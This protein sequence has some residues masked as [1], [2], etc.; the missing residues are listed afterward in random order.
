MAETNT[1][2]L[3]VEIIDLQSMED[4]TKG[5]ELITSDDRSFQ[6]GDLVEGTILSASK[7][8]MI[9]DLDGIASGIIT[10]EDLF[11]SDNTVLTAQP[12][13]RTMAMI[14]GMES[15]DGQYRM[16]LKRAARQGTW[17]RFL[18]AFE[19]DEVVE[20]N[21]VDANKGGL[22]VEQNGIRGFI[23]V[24]QLSPENYP[25]VNGADSARILAKLQSLVGTRMKAKILNVDNAEQRLIF[26]EREAYTKDRMEVIGKLK[27]GETVKCRV[28]GVVNFGVFLNY[29]GIEGLVHISEIAWGHVS[30]PF[31]FYKAGDEVEA[32]IISIEGEKISFSIKRLSDDPW[33]K[34]IENY[35]VGQAV[36][37]SVVRITP[38][39]VF[40][41]IQQDLEG[42]VHV[43]ELADGHVSD[44]LEVVKLGDE[45]DARIVTIDCDE[46]KISLSVKAMA[47]SEEEF[48]KSLQP[49]ESADAPAKEESSEVDDSS[50]SSD[51]KD[52]E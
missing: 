28:S 34:V 20:V 41:K 43:S 8:R 5:S 44:P 24:S 30:N 18:K 13:D 27:V 25:R 26:S 3:K 40:V 38:F 39:G 36:K 2:G 33:L 21:I 32:M 29:E 31:S 42:L 4:L 1:S 15:T 37:G 35:K 22:L 7:S 12:G 16:S 9:L 46:H 49:E 23:P 6:I 19:D 50:E 51:D 52:A 48:L 45:L 17:E 10:G 11:D 47:K 14:I